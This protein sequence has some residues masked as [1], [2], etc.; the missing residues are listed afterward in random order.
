MI[1]ALGCVAA[2]VA[3]VAGCSFAGGLSTA[4]TV[5]KD[6]LQTEIATRLTK[7]GE[8]PLIGEVGQTAHCEVV[9]SPTNSFEPAALS[10]SQARRPD[11][12]LRPTADLTTKT[13][14]SQPMPPRR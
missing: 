7:A 1:P 5:S 6:A 4:P 14:L 8:H 13:H 9:L 2:T 10:R 11:D 3:L 12:E